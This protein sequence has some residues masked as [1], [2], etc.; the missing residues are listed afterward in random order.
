VVQ[1]LP[2]R[3]EPANLGWPYVEVSQ[4]GK[5]ITINLVTITLAALEIIDIRVRG[6][7]QPA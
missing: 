6:E 1:P 3:H 5:V 2:A 7:G 4:D